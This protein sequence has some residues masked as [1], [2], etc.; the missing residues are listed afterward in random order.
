MF[1]VL[2]YYPKNA[3]LCTQTKL[4][5]IENQYFAYF[6]FLC[7]LLMCLLCGSDL[8]VVLIYGF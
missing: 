1:N 8:V 2:Y 6:Y 3:L 4:T 7:A 5:Y